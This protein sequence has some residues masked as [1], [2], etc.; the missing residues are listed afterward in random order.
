[1]K[2]YGLVAAGPMR[3][4]DLYH[5]LYSQKLFKSVEKAESYKETFIEACLNSDRISDL[6]DL[7]RVDKIQIIEYEIEDD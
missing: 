4:Y 1:M 2:L 7:K 6:F 5:K 3:G